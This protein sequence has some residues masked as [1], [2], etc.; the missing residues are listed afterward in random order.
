M[1][2]I[3]SLLVVAKKAESAVIYGAHWCGPC[4]RAQDY[5]KQRGVAVTFYDI[6]KE[7]QRKSEMQKKLLEGYSGSDKGIPVIEVGGQ[8]FVGFR[9]TE[10]DQALVSSTP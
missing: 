4:H 10:L 2:K 6:E 8:I 1:I 9:P 7:P 3:A 5:L